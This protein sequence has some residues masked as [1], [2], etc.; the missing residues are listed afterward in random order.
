MIIKSINN[1]IGYK[2]IPD[3]FK[4]EFDTK[5][6][7]VIGDNAKTKSTILEIPF[8]AL[9]GYNLTGSDRDQFKDFR[10]PELQSILIDITI[11]DNEGRERN[12]VRSRGKENYILID[13]IKT[14]QKDLAILYDNKNVHIFT[15]AYNPYYFRSLQQAEQRELLIN[16]LP[17]I[18]A[19]EAFE[20][21]DDI[22]KKILEKPIID[23]N[24]FCKN[25]RQENKKIL[26]DL[27][28]NEGKITMCQNTA[29]M[30]EGEI[31]EF[32]NEMKL[33]QLIS[34][35]EVLM[36]KSNVKSNLTE[37]ETSIKSLEDRIKN[38]LQTELIEVKRDY[39]KQIEN[40]NNIKSYKYICPQCKQDVQDKATIERMVKQYK[41]KIKLLIEKIDKMK[42]DAQKMIE[43]RKQKVNQYMLLKTPEIQNIEKQKKS[44]KSKIELLQGE[45]EKIMLNNRE[46]EAK[47]K[48]IKEAK[49]ML[50][51]LYK[52][53]IE[54][55]ES[56]EKNKIQLET[57]DRLKRTIIEEQLK[58]VKQYL[59]HV[60]IELSCLDETT[61]EM[62]DV[63]IV[64]YDD[65]E[66]KNLSKSYRMR[67][68]FE[69]ANLISHASGI[70]SPMVMDDAES[71]AKINTIVDGQIIISM[72]VEGSELKVL[73]DYK[74]V[75]AEMRNS[76]NKQI[77]NGS[78][79]ILSNAA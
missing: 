12:I 5:L 19:E 16:L 48:M 75:L 37:L 78:K 68:D 51:I 34:E 33:Q 24:G 50:E 54:M 79:Y 9:T 2:G 30:Q 6:T 39:S 21:L 59:E 57:A 52:A 65:T 1:V 41:S 23:I 15:C 66:Y 29:L 17:N 27:N 74:D 46:V 35:Y 71:I 40:L 47:R 42:N 55:K 61:G 43:L 63:Y 14:T 20:L 3:G 11:I 4:M 10:R 62:K 49:D 13:G 31:I 25:K 53:N 32:S 67:A 77:V 22:D 64:K 38:L 26:E 45:K 70:N 36:K 18:S 28:I 44:I 69:I 58:S 8:F 56:I 76:I 7:Y 60:T 73:Y 72:V